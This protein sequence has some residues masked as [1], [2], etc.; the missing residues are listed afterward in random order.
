VT[1]EDQITALLAEAAPLR[2]LP[3]EEQGA[4]GAVV[5]E[6]NRLRALQAKGVIEF[7]A[8]KRGPGRPK[9]AE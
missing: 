4:L 6:I 1:L 3:E 5:D 9:K 8:P 2:C 7:D